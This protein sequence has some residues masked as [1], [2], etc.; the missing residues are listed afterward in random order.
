MVDRKEFVEIEDRDESNSIHAG[1][2]ALVVPERRRKTDREIKE[3]IRAL[4]E[5]RRVLRVERGSR[6]SRELI[7][8]RDRPVE[9]VVEVRKDR[10]GRMSLVVPK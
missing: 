7:I 4:E 2:L 5:E 9:E 10:K 3:Q 6:E 1:P 8:E